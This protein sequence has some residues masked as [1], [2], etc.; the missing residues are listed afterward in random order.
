MS[1]NQAELLENQDLREKYMERTEVLD[2]VKELLLLDEFEVMT[3]EMVVKY[4]E[5]KE[6]TIKSLL[7]D[8]KEEVESDGYKV[9]TKDEFIE[10]FLLSS[11]KKL[12]TKRGGFDV[13]DENG[14]VIASGSN[15]GIALFPRRAVLRIAM[16]LKKS[17][18]AIEVRTQLLNIEEKATKEQKTQEI[19]EEQML[20]LAIMTAKSDAERAIAVNEHLKYVNRYKEKAE[21]YETI[22]HSDKLY[23]TTE[24]A[25]DCGISAVKL[26]RILMDKK[27]T[28][29]KGNTYY[30][31]A[32]HEDKVPSH[33]DYHISE[34]GQTLKWTNVGREWI[35]ELLKEDN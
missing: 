10:Q 34:Y 15:T 24:V 4:F 33:A 28:Y 16:L 25:K 5:T 17:N 18:I 7:F 8:H 29:K 30:F 12:K 9:Y 1:I 27:I 20:L 11:Q 26:N 2:K 32:N 19:T 31:Y 14:E 35:M 6:S 22:Y 13:L 3:S 23:T 21:R